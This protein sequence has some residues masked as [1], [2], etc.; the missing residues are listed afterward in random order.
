MKVI[1]IIIF[2]LAV[3][4][5]AL[6]QEDENNFKKISK[7]QKVFEFST[8]YKELYYNFAN[9]NDCP[10]VDIDSVYKAYITKILNSGNC[11]FSKCCS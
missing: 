8:I 6:A 5:S 3:S 9:F 7:E 1:K 11:R 2:I 10:D 4:F